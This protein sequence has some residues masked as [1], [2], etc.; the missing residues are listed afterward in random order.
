[1]AVCLDHPAV[2]VVGNLTGP[3][4]M[5]KN[6]SSP[7]L[8]SAW[9]TTSI[10]ARPSHLRTFKASPGFH[11]RPS[12]LGVAG[13][14]PNHLLW[15]HFPSKNQGAPPQFGVRKQRPYVGI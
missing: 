2:V 15:S 10:K 13:V 6:T 3:A 7:R 5:G 11:A 14:D 8:G 4:D 12:T 9:G 1:M